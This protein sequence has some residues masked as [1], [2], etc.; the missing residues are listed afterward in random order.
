MFD[1]VCDTLATIGKRHSKKMA[2][3]TRK[4]GVTV[5]TVGFLDLLKSIG[6]PGAQRIADY[7]FTPQF[8]PATDALGIGVWEVKVQ[9]LATFESLLFNLSVGTT[10]QITTP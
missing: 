2:T 4:T 9:M 6:N 10:V 8:A 7:Q 5:D 1:Y 3:I